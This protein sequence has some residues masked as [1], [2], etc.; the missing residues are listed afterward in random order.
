VNI[1]IMSNEYMKVSQKIGQVGGIVLRQQPQKAEVVAQAIGL[2]Y[3]SA[4]KFKIHTLPNGKVVK[5]E[6]HDEKGW[7]PRYKEL[8]ELDAFLFAQEESSFCTRFFFTFLGCKN[9]RPLKMHITVDGNTGDVY[10]I[11]RPFRFGALCCH[12]FE[13][14]LS[15]IHDGH[16]RR[17]GRARESLTPF[18]SRCGAACCL[19]TTYTDIET[20]NASTSAF[21]HKYTLRT[22]LSC[23]GRVNNFCGGS[24]CKNDAV[25]DILDT[26]DNVVAHL[27][28]TYGGGGFAALCRMGAGFNN[29]ILEFPA[30]S[31]VDERMLLVTALFQ[32][33]YIFF[34]RQN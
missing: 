32:I 12:P 17:L 24:C 15:A 1:V 11:H 33:E 31:T 26:S 28:K 22:N 30:D 13:M 9:L 19:A 8:Q 6:P 21:E 14:N 18:F 10:T 4:N 2:P 20:Y 23:C 16:V 27:Q 34:E 3:E 25:F 7:E 29:Y 5:S